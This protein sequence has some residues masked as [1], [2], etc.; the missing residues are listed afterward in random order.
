VI[1]VPIY[2]G[3]FGK[4]KKGKKNL[5]TTGVTISKKY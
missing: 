4:Q 1:K 5:T 2:F 3:N